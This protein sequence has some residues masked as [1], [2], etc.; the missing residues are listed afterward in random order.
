MADPTSAAATP[1][2]VTAS[3]SSVVAATI[4]HPQLE[5][6]LNVYGSYGDQEPFLSAVNFGDVAARDK[7]HMTVGVAMLKK[8][9]EECQIELVSPLSLSLSH[10]FY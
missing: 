6:L 9:M 10:L 8:W 7:L 1:V 2:P 4:P 3:A 5:S